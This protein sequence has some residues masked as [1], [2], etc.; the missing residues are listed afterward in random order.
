MFKEIK[1]LSTE[2]VSALSQAVLAPCQQ[3]KYA[4]KA[5][6]DNKFQSLFEPAHPVSAS[7]LFGDNLNVELKELEN[8][9]VQSSVE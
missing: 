7:E 8:R 5:E 6:W 3:R 1:K 2:A 9:V 4:I